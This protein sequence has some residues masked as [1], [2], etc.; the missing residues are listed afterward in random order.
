MKLDVSDLRNFYAAPLG[1]VVRRTLAKRIRARW[2]SLQGQKLVGLGY[3]SPYLGP[4]RAEASHIAAF[5]PAMQGAIAWPRTSRILSALVENHRLPLADN[6]IDRLLV[7]HCLETAER[8]GP[9]LREMWRVMAPEGRLLLIVPNRRGLWARMDSTPFGQGHPYSRRQLDA[10]LQEA[11]FTPTE[12]GSALHVPPFEYRLLLGSA[13]AW[14][15][16]GG[17]VSPG[18]AGVIIVEAQKELVAPAGK[19]LKARTIGDY[20]M[21]GR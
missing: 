7:V 17:R 6:S 19:A 12:W 1:Q 5:M 10:L 4:Y 3:A 8:V 2:S 14:E 13:P 11:L 16:V 21:V 15:R 18:F 9:L 20:V